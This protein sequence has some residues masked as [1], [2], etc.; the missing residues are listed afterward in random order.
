MKAHK[1]GCVRI[2]G[3]ILNAPILNLSVLFDRYEEL[4][5]SGAHILEVSCKLCIYL[6]VLN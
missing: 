6:T 5:T 3:A 2:D 1:D 4:C